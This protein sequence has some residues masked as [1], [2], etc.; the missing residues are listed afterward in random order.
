MCMITSCHWLLKLLCLGPMSG[1]LWPPL[2]V[3][4]TLALSIPQLQMLFTSESLDLGHLCGCAL[5][6][7][8]C[9]LLCPP[10]GT[11]EGGSQLRKLASQLT[12]AIWWRIGGH[13][14]L[15]K[16]KPGNGHRPQSR[17]SPLVYRN[18]GNN[19]LWEF[20]RCLGA[21]NI[22]SATSSS[23]LGKH[24][25]SLKSFFLPSPLY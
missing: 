10:L 23:S 2:A 7:I 1:S 12:A 24:C 16:H 22:C 5:G 14:T 19:Y 17:C 6:G 4:L 9:Q 13:F 20:H 25:S 8:F 15:G 3:F 11:R 18:E 21:P